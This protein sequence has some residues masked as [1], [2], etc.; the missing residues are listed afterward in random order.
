MSTLS[1]SVAI[2]LAS[3]LDNA[4]IDMHK[5]LEETN[6]PSYSKV[7]HSIKDVQIIKEKDEKL[8]ELSNIVSSLTEESL[9]FM[10]LIAT[11]DTKAFTYDDV[12]KLINELY[13]KTEKVLEVSEYQFKNTAG[14]FQKEHEKVLYYTTVFN[15]YLFALIDED[16]RE[17]TNFKRT[18][19][20]NI[21]ETGKKLYA[22][23]VRAQGMFA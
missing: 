2:L 6:Q 8:K 19:P 7:T 9:Q 10:H 15:T 23:N 4:P 3:L 18:V 16:S 21:F 11:L 22:M 1:A 17:I 5:Y 20:E 14:S 13:S 12:M